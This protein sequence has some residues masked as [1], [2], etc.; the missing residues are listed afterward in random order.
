MNNQKNHK[1][2]R[3]EKEDV[4]HRRPKQDRKSRQDHKVLLRT[5]RYEEVYEQE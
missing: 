3:E 5:G 4:D 1:R 2:S